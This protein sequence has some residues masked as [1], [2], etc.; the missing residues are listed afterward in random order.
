[1]VLTFIQ[2]NQTYPGPGLAGEDMAIA[3][4]EHIRSQIE[5]REH[6]LMAF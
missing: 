2:A 4:S 6:V 3:A 5:V 1:M